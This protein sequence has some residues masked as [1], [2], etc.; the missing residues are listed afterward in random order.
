[1]TTTEELANVIEKMVAEKISEQMKVLEET[2]FAKSKQTLFTKAE[3]AEKWGCV[4]STVDVILKEKSVFPKGKR[5]KEF[6]YDV[7]QAQEAKDYHDGKILNKHEL[8][9]KMRAM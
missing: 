2:Y 7:E 9:W 3:L 5:G 4:I 8:N 6:E 1:M